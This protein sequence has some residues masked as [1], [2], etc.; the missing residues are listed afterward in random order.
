MAIVTLSTD[1][2]QQDYIVGAIKGQLLS[3]NQGL[4]IV[5]I[6]HYLSQS[7]FPEA[8]YICSNAFQHFPNKTIHIVLLHFFENRVNHLLL[9]EYKDQFIICADNGILMMIT[10]EK[11]SK[12]HKISFSNSKTFL[13]TTNLIAKKVNELSKCFNI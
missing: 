13:E 12:V 11:P 8:A 9:A 1:I 2:G 10:H 6:S 4:N 3:Y 5:D 7:N